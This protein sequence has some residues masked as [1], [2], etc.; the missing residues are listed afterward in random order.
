MRKGKL[1]AGLALG[2][3]V[4]LTLTSFAAYRVVKWAFG[5][6]APAT[7]M[8]QGTPATGASSNKAV[9][10]APDAPLPIVVED[11]VDGAGLP[12]R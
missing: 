10:S 6:S 8:A 2:L 12:Q 3:V 1:I 4:L 11:E 5:E 9:T 7:E